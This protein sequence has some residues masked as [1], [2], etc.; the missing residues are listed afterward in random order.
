MGT[1]A[2]LR[3]KIDQ[4][5]EVGLDKF[6]NKY[7]QDMEKY[8]L[9]AE[10]KYYDDYSSWYDPFRRYDIKNM[11]KVTAYSLGHGCQVK[12]DFS[13]SHMKGG[14]GMWRP[15]SEYAPD[16]G[17][18]FE[19]GF[20]TGNHGWNVP[21]TPVRTYWEVYYRTLQNRTKSWANRFVVQGLR[22]VGL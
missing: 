6:V 7:K 19:W 11:H 16:P 12:I 4:G 10:E 3:E 8:A 18:V 2:E 9:K 1:I 22:S 5:I 21:G 15:L 13:P 14:H 20:E 17:Q